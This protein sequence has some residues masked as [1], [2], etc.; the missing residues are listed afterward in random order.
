MAPF[1]TSAS[2]ANSAAATADAGGGLDEVRARAEESLAASE[3]SKR[4]QARSRMIAEGRLVEMPAG[5]TKAET[6]IE[7]E[8]RA[9]EWQRL[10]RG[11]EWGNL[12]AALAQTV[13]QGPSGGALAF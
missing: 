11:Q 4:N 6:K 8:V 7:I 2:A 12:R 10:A 9:A 13:T 3:E 1:P 5:L